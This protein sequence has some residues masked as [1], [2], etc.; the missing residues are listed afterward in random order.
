MISYKETIILFLAI[1]M[2]GIFMYFVEQTNIDKLILYAFIFLVAIAK[3]FYFIRSNYTK[4]VRFSKINISYFGF[5]LFVAVNILLMV[6]SFGIDYFSIFIIDHNSFSGVE[7]ATTIP[8]QLFKFFYLSFLLFTNMGVANV[9]PATTPAEFMVMFEAIISFITIIFVL[10]D[11]ANLKA[12]L[13]KIG[14]RKAYKGF[15]KI[16]YRIRR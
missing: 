10:S 12:S 15:R 11:F 3:L 13:N 7:D 2:L 4:L 16:N 9:V 8:Q 14:K 5:L 6:F 1:L